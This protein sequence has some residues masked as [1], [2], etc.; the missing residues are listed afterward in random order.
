MVAQ[1]SSDGVMNYIVSAA[2]NGAIGYDEYSYALGQ[3]LPG[4]QDPEQRRLLHAAH[5]VQRRGG[6]ARRRS[7][8]TDKSSPNYLLQDL[9]DV[10]TYTDPRTYPLSSYSYAIIPT[11]ATDTRMTTAKRQTL[12]DFLYYSVCQGQ[13]EIG[14]VGYSAA[15]A[16]PGAGQFR[17][18]RAS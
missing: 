2:A 17:P 15:A 8:N 14:P 4:R 1:T 7:I 12:A 16:E 5:P 9:H 11:S 13:A 10:Y 6:A 18:D 3:E